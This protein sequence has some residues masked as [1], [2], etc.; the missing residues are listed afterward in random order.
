MA[1]LSVKTNYK[2]VYNIRHGNNL[3]QQSL[4][5]TTQVAALIQPF[6]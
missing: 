4:D 3:L 1:S 5:I 6:V 2:S